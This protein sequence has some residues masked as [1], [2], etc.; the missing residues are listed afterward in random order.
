MKK[1]IKNLEPIICDCCGKI[2]YSA[3]EVC[4]LLG[5]EDVERA[6]NEL[7]P[8]M[9]SIIVYDSDEEGKDLSEPT[10]MNVLNLEGI[11]AL[12]FLS[13]T[14][15]AKIIQRRIIDEYVEKII[16]SSNG[17]KLRL[18]PAKVKF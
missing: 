16:S 4:N 3:K 14:P 18:L 13:P 1:F 9:K 6:L 11:F 5:L 10:E 17:K 8:D 12:V 7:D 15:F 2:T